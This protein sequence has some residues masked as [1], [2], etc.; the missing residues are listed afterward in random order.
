MLTTINFRISENQKE[1]LQVLAEEKDE[2]ISTVLREIIENYL[3]D[4][5]YKESKPKWDK[6][7]FEVIYLDMDD[8]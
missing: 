3:E 6:H 4:H 2:K 1:K 8:F 5:D 7:D